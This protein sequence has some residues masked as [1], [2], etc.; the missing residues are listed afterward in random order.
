[1]EAINVQREKTLL[2]LENTCLQQKEH[3]TK[4]NIDM[5]NCT[6]ELWV[7]IQ[8]LTRQLETFRKTPNKVSQTTYIDNRL[9]EFDE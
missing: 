1:M 5:E 8:K 4:V 3:L 6:H 9:K 7:Q 2:K